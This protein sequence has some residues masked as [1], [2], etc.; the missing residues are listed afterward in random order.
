MTEMTQAQ[1]VQRR[2]LAQ[3]QPEKLKQLYR[4]TCI[5]I[6]VL[7]DAA[8]VLQVTDLQAVLNAWN[9]WEDVY[10]HMRQRDY[11]HRWMEYVRLLAAVERIN[12]T[13]TVSP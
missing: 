6:D 8:I 9:A 11:E 4:M 12:A 2:L 3:T 10:D 1:Q 13:H 7:L 5:P